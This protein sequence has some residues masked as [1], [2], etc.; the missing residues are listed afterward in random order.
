MTPRWLLTAA[1]LAVLTATGIALALPR[2]LQARLNDAADRWTW[3]LCEA[4]A[5]A[6]D[7]EV[8]A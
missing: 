5:A 3:E 8:A 4:V 6:W 7:E 2:R 1:A